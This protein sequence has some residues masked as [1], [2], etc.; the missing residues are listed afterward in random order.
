MA[1]ILHSQG[2][3]TEAE[4]LCRE[5][6]GGFVAALGPE[7][8]FAVSAAENLSA[9]LRKLGKLDEADSLTQKFNLKR[10]LGPVTEGGGGAKGANGKSPNGKSPKGKKKQASGI[11][12][13]ADGEE[14]GTDCPIEEVEDVD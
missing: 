10:P 7:H 14:E 2:K 13:Q 5:V 4:P 11:A 8:P 12:E 6:L 3:E 9:V 1:E